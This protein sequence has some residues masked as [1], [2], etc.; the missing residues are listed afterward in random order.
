MKVI[1][2]RTIKARNY[3]S[4]RDVEINLSDFNVIIG[5]NSAGKSN[6][7]SILQ[8]FRDIINSGVEN[9]ISLQ[10]GLDYILN[11]ND[12]VMEIEIVFNHKMAF[13]FN[14]TK[15]FDMQAFSYKI[16]LE[17]LKNSRKL[18][19]YKYKESLELDL[20]DNSKL[21][22]YNNNGKIVMDNALNHLFGGFIGVVAHGT[23]DRSILSLI[24]I[25]PFFDRG[26][27][28]QIY[29][30]DP[31]L[32]KRSIP[33]SGLAE[34][35]PDGRNI[36]LVLKDLTKNSDSLKKLISLVDV[37]IPFINKIDTE[38]L[39]DKSILLNIKENFN[40]ELKLPATF[41]S[42]GTIEIITLIDIL[43][44]ERRNL[45]AIEEPE[46]NLHPA[47]LQKIMEL[48]KEASKNKQ[49]IITT[50]SPEII[51]YVDIKNILII[52][53]D[54]GGFSVIKKAEDDTEL[55]Y[56]LKENIRISQLFS[57]GLLN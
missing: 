45:V 55:K 28:P 33:I 44:F 14:S 54:K 52:K 35:E 49:L 4:F 40:K 47:L 21:S 27:I 10:G 3:K 1:Q 36:A 8:F 13:N 53:R 42:D 31:K 29:D 24:P 38:S 2:I 16:Q 18:K 25:I 50:H 51:N 20:K 9:A 48:M 56:F 17:F 37:C 57:D 39:A 11:P 26:N 43:F 23:S 41:I 34:L 22:I 32:S 30:I 46:K 19:K 15:K 12:K 5:P 6:F 7:L